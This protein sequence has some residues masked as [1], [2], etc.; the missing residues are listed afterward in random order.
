[1]YAK[2]FKLKLPSL[3]NGINWQPHQQPNKQNTAANVHE[4]QPD[5][6][7]IILIS[8]LLHDGL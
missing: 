4:K 1:M 2:F 3:Q 6:L 7:L 5:F 8:L